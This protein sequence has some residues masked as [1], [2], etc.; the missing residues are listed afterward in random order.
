[1][2]IAVHQPHY[3]PNLA[4]LYK[5][6]CADLFVIVT[7]LQF[8]R[9]EGWQR[10]HK[11]PGNHGDLWLTVP[12]HG[13]QNTLIRDVTIDASSDW[14][15]RHQK[16]LEHAYAKTREPE[17]LHCLAA[18]YNTPWRRLVDVNVSFIEFMRERLRI[19]TPVIVDEEV[20]GKRSQLPINV[21]KKYGGETYLAGRGAQQYMTPS[22]YAEFE[23]ESITHRYVDR[24][25]SLYPYSTIHYL[26]TEGVDAVR[27]RLRR[28]SAVHSSSY[29]KFFSL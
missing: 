9:R 21:C 18:A 7:N 17:L 19:T 3:L 8:E 27:E 15:Y 10:R 23:N 16:T 22:L 13:S 11:I 28:P 24:D 5:M 6:A 12:V 2:V 26:F 29:E 14:R 1:M 25:F 4:F 20:I